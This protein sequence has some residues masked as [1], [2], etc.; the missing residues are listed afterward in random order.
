MEWVSSGGHGSGF[1]PSIGIGGYF[2]TVD[3][4]DYD[5]DG[6]E[7][8]RWDASYP[9]STTCLDPD[10]VE[11]GSGRMFSV[12]AWLDSVPDCG[13]SG[14]W[15]DSCEYEEFETGFGSFGMWSRDTYIGIQACN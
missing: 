13:E 8:L 1:G 15:W 2:I 9:E 7:T 5:C 11:Y 14:T 3:T 12:D 10:V 4:W 6:A